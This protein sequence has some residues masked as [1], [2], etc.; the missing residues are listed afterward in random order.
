LRE[1]LKPKL[2]GRADD[3]A[4]WETSSSS[5]SE[6]MELSASASVLP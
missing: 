2:S 1:T 3:E 4:E 5:V 6:G